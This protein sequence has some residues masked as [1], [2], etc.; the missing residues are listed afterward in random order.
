MKHH[1]HLLANSP[2]PAVLP[3]PYAPLDKPVK[4]CEDFYEL[5]KENQCKKVLLH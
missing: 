5:A 3:F 1:E 4:G 2:A